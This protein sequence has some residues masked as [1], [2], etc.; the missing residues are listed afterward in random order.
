MSTWDLLCEFK[1]GCK[2]ENQSKVTFFF[3]QEV[4]LK[5][6]FTILERIASVAKPMK[7]TVKMAP[8]LDIQQI[9]DRT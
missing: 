5:F 3:N 4:I 6:T 8:W 2:T 7:I 9:L 1:R